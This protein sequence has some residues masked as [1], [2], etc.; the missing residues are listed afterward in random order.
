[1]QTAMQKTMQTAIMDAF[2]GHHIP[3][4]GYAIAH[5][6]TQPEP[7]QEP[8]PAAAVAV[9]V[10]VAAAVGNEA[11]VDIETAVAAHAADGV[12]GARIYVECFL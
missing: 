12:E 10:A 1:M 3:A 9:A 8:E 6:Q 11:V 5:V 7:E 4:Q 2:Q